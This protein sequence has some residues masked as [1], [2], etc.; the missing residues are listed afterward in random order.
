MHR[1]GFA[2]V[3]VL[4][5]CAA[6]PQ[7]APAPRPASDQQERLV[8]AER[9]YRS[10]D[11]GFDA[12]RDE[13]AGDPVTARWLTRMFI[14]DL[15]WARDQRQADDEAFIGAVAGRSEH[16]VEVRA[17]RHLQAIGAAAAPA[18]IEDLLRSPYS[19]RRQIGTE[20][21]G[22][23][24]PVTLPALQPL[25]VDGDRSTRRMA[26][27]A[28]VEMEKTPAV[29]TAL[30]RAVVDGDFTVRAEAVE[31]LAR[32]GA[33]AAPRLRD[34]LRSDADPFVRRVVAAQLGAFHDA[35]TARALVE[36]LE[37]CVA[38]GDGRGIEATEA[39]LI[40]IAGRKQSG[41]L[42]GWRRWLSGFA[43]GGG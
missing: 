38:D 18:L 27:S 14:R 2:A 8:E 25:L 13:L 28:L 43:G 39:A 21:L 42:A 41:G 33:D 20:L 40:E 9:L 19:D 24:G 15:I 6:G 11:P 3:V 34:L 30:E 1:S 10:G 22:A 26:V 23:V 4:A 16:P 29:R 5:A 32:I 36:Y 7:R 31:G 37:R 12:A 35:E 17:W